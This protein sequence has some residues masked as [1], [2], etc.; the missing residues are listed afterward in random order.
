[1][2][3][4]LPKI[5]LFRLLRDLKFFSQMFFIIFWIIPPIIKLFFCFIELFFLTDGHFLHRFLNRHILKHIK[6]LLDNK[7][8]KC[9]FVFHIK[10]W[11][12]RI[13]TECRLRVIFLTIL[14]LCEGYLIFCWILW[15]VIWSF[16]FFFVIHAKF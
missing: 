14:L 3:F 10:N 4:N 13:S 6:T 7:F 12:L 9:D 1:M 15:G 8:G 2:L 11:P 16:W 5:I